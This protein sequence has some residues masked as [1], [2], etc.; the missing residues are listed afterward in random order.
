V[1][2]SVELCSLTLQRGDISMANLISSGLF[3]DGAAAVIVAGTDTDTDADGGLSGPRILAD[4][5]S[6]LSQH[7]RDDGLGRIGEGLSHR[8]LPR[9]PELG[10][11]QSGARCR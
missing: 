4:P 7:G 11:K 2:F 8:A 5:F 1:V 9:S 10:S 3:G 6:V